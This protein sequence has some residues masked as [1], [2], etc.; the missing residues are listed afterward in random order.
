VYHRATT[1]ATSSRSGMTGTLREGAPA[2]RATGAPPSTAAAA[3]I[4]PTGS[5]SPAAILSRRS[6][7][8]A[9]SAGIRQHAI[10]WETAGVHPPPTEGT[11]SS[12]TSRDAR[13]RHGSGVVTASVALEP[14]ATG[15]ACPSRDRHAAPRP[16]GSGCARIAVTGGAEGSR[17][18]RR[19]RRDRQGAAGTGSGSV[20]ASASGRGDGRQQERH[21]IDVERP[22]P[23]A[24][25]QVGFREDR[26]PVSASIPSLLPA[27]DRPRPRHRD[28]RERRVRQPNVSALDGD[29][30]RRG[31][32]ACRHPARE[33]HRAVEHP[34][35]CTAGRGQ[36]DCPGA[37]T[38]SVRAA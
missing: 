33:R 7:A 15:V 14:L 30:E 29:R 34:G 5:A 10:A 9:A 12:P 11:R 8:S 2:T 24:Q 3:T 22:A 27:I 28:L 19:G 31:A 32:L 20:H 4:P 36:I 35:H 13:R 21:G 26:S 6:T 1:A 23:G 25:V 18:G 16:A 17:N 38:R 37:P